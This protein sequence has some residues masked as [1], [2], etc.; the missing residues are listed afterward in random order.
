MFD[1]APLDRRNGFAWDHAPKPETSDSGG[2]RRLL[3]D[4]TELA[5]L[6]GR[7]AINDAK[8]LAES[9]VTPTIL[10][11]AGLVLLLGTVPVIL[12]SAANILVEE[13]EWSVAG[14]QA[15]VAAVAIVLA[16]LIVALAI[17]RLKAC[18][19]PLSRST[20]E[21]E[22]NLAHHC[23]DTRL[24]EFARHVQVKSQVTGPKNDRVLQFQTHILRFQI[25]HTIP[26]SIF[27]VC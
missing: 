19:A 22:K 8:C 23:G 11:V 27:L 10:A 12:L 25:C 17:M 26:P 1:K 24:F 20:E 14:A 4:M 18:G 15:L 6:Q 7:L 3:A 13:T 9:V 16:A 5:E 2:V 21:L